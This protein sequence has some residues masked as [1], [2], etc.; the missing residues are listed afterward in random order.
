MNKEK[1]AR[2]VQIDTQAQK[3][4]SYTHDTNSYKFRRV[5]YPQGEAA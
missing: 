1:N 5:A 2:K 3:K 4:A